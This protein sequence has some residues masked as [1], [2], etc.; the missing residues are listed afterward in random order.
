M[1]PPSSYHHHNNSA[2]SSNNNITT[3]PQSAQTT[4]TNKSLAK[5]VLL[6]KDE[7]FL[8]ED[9]ITYY[10][11]LFGYDNAIVVDNGSTCQTVL[12]VYEW[13]SSTHGVH[14][15]LDKRDF[16]SATVFMSEH[17]REVAHFCEW[18]L[19]LETDEF[20]FNMRGG[21][22]GG[23][24]STND[25]LFRL[26][27]VD[28]RA[29]LKSLPEDVSIVNYGSVLKSVVDPY[30][31]TYDMSKG[32][33]PRPTTYI[34]RFENQNWDKLIV[35]ASEFLLMNMWCHH[36]AVKTGCR[37]RS[38]FLR[39]LHFHETGFRRK[40]ESAVRVL[41][42]FPYI[43]NIRG[44][45][46]Q[47][48]IE[49]VRRKH[50]ECQKYIE[51][52]V[53]CEHKIEY[54][55]V[56]L[57]RLLALRAFR[58][59]LGRNPIDPEEFNQVADDPDPESAVANF[60]RHKVRVPP[61]VIVAETPPPPSPTSAFYAT[62]EEAMRSHKSSKNTVHAYGPLYAFLFDPLRE[63]DCMEAIL[64]IGVQ[65]EGSFANAFSA[66]FP[67][68]AIVGIVAPTDPPPPIESPDDDKNSMITHLQ[69]EGS[70]T[71]FARQLDVHF[72]LI[73]HTT[74][75]SK[76]GALQAF[77][78]YLKPGGLFVIESVIVGSAAHHQ[79]DLPSL[80]TEMDANATACGLVTHKWY[81][82][83]NVKGMPEDVVARIIMFVMISIAAVLFLFVLMSM[84]TTA[85]LV[86]LHM[87]GCGWCERFMPVWE[88]MKTKHG[89]GGVTMLKYERSDPA[90]KKYLPHATGF[91]TILLDKGSG[92]QKFSGERTV[93]GLEAFLKANGVSLLLTSKESFAEGEAA[94]I[95]KKF[96]MLKS[97][98]MN[99]AVSSKK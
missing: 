13:Y 86:L 75:A 26:M 95:K 25:P 85:T 88:E 59:V 87:D 20:V 82:L 32:M 24:S 19:P 21:G 14:I 92:V 72:D 15:K 55:D 94:A 79:R 33:Y 89:K 42:T 10:G 9:F 30:D 74:S 71:E 39:L 56:Y 51:L 65:Q 70:S 48:S 57:R 46:E 12:D 18:I 58:N 76:V 41:R 38:E 35:R 98:V 52:G 90:A 73:V 67:D 61:N 99:S 49:D 23:G 96:S 7:S 8:I 6:T 16:S 31:K 64:E 29:Y 47:Q 11:E 54:Y 80:M 44:I 91:P 28:V 43:D 37:V 1:P 45:D 63:T 36:A 93:E 22:G 62:F 34:T 2:T 77:A 53:V 3:T 83:R 97:Q 84:K 4:T 40:I 50:T 81:D 27:P 78:P 69:G 5:V 60:F 66:F 68:A 17:M